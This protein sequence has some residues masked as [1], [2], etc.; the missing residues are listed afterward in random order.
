MKEVEFYIAAGRPYTTSVKIRRRGKSS[1]R[2]PAVYALFALAAI[3]SV[4]PYVLSPKLQIGFLLIAWSP[5][6][7]LPITSPSLRQ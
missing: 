5:Y 4:L 3:V 2:R 6:R 1:C 7:I